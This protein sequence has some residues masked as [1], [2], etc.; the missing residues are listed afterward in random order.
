MKFFLSMLLIFM[1]TSSVK[2]QNVFPTSA[3]SKVGIGTTTPGIPLEVNTNTVSDSLVVAGFF[4]PSNTGVGAATKVRIGATNSK[5]NSAELRYVH[6]GND[7]ANN[8]MDFGFHSYTTPVISYTRNG[9]FGIGTTVPTHPLTL[10][11]LSSGIALYNTSDQK[12]NY[13]R[14]AMSWGSGVFEIKT[15]NGG[16]GTLRNVNVNGTRFNP[17]GTFNTNGIYANSFGPEGNNQSINFGNYYSTTVSSGILSFMSI[18]PTINQT[19]TAGYSVLRISPF[20]QSV[21][22]GSKYLLDIGTNSQGGGN[23]T[24]TSKFIVTNGG[25]VGIGT[26][27]IAD[28]GYLLFV[29]KGIR[30]RK[31]KVDAPSIAWPDYIFDK[32]YQLLPLADLAKYIN[33]KKHLPDIPSSSEVQKRGIDLGDNQTRLLMKV[34]ELTLYLIELDK[35]VEALS[36]ENKILRKQLSSTIK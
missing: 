13:E 12:I 34:E 28:T 9:F 20:E 19:L 7:S 8:R 16:T 30:T 24:H 22:N 11:A 33:A 36:I 31:L 4:G 29:E 6:N 2:S 21:G 25:S 26:T 32:S 10:P 3:G 14:L 15:Q 17:N 27:Q 23:G 1:I 5:G 35:K 18:I